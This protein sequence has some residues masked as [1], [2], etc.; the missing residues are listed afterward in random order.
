MQNK[1]PIPGFS[2]LILVLVLFPMTAPQ[3]S[4]EDAPGSSEPEGT[5]TITP[6]WPK[7]MWEGHPL[8]PE[9]PN[10]EKLGE[11]RL[12]F[13][14]PAGSSN[15]AAGK[16][17]TSSDPFPIIGE[18]KMLTDGVINSRDGVI[19]LAFRKQWIQIDLK[20]E[21]NIHAIV[22]WRYYAEARVYKDVVIQVSNDPEFKEGVTTVFNNDDD[23]SSGFGKGKDP[24]YFETNYGRI[25]DVDGIKGRYVRFYSNGNTENDSNHYIEAQ[26]WGTPAAKKTGK[27]LKI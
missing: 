6:D 22:V 2:S 27:L 11:P 21:A 17:V 24:T 5:E 13:T 1:I 3:S 7:P 14:V 4:S 9:F 25:I 26:V 15:L 19:E 20:A 12:S 10:M 16:P 23:G 8:S 18:P